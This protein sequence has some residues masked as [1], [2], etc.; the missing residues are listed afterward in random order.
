MEMVKQYAKI[1]KRY[2]AYTYSYS[3][4]SVSFEDMEPQPQN[5]TKRYLRIQARQFGSKYA[6]A[7]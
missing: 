6:L 1:D 5:L 4:T 3:L 2:S 7:A